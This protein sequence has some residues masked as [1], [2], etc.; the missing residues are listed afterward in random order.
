MKKLTA[1]F[2]LLILFAFDVADIRSIYNIPKEASGVC[3]TD[4]DLDG[5]LDIVVNHG[6]DSQTNWGGIYILQNDGYGHFTFMDSIFDSVGWVNYA[7]TVISKVYPDIVYNY[8]DS[9]TVLATDGINYQKSFYFVGPKVNDFALG[10]VDGNGYLDVVFISNNN[11]YWG[12]IYNQDGSNFTYPEYYNLD[13]APNDIACKDLNK[14]GKDDIVLAGAS[15]ESEIW[16]STENGFE[17]QSLPFGAFKIGIAD[18]DND[19]DQDII[20]FSDIVLVSRVYVYENLNGDAFDTVGTFKI[21]GGCS[22]FFVTDFNNDSLPDLLF[23]TYNSSR[24]L[25]LYYNKGSFQ[26]GDSLEFDLDYYGEAR[27]FMYCADMD[28]NGYNDIIISRQVYDLSYNSSPLEILFN[29]GE[30]NFVDDPL[31]TIL[32]PNPELKTLNLS[33]F[34]NPFKDRINIEYT[35]DKNSLAQLDIYGLNGHK[36]KT[37]NNK[38]LKAGKYIHTWNG[39]DKKG[40]EVKTGVYIIR[41]VAG[42]QTH[43]CRVV[44]M[45]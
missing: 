39:T 26:F 18:L 6:I 29:D 3:A 38:L 10:D 40:K 35:I 28:G 8:H 41:L 15:L 4:Y 22:K 43:S 17:K 36:I 12:I 37:L 42:R 23:M 32:T 7:D 14:N 19:D 13:N 31:T 45:K 44:Y 11:H 21:P 30:G 5:D 24:D 27:R 33:C 20:T 1:T 25:L 9:I 16:F 2:I 34:P